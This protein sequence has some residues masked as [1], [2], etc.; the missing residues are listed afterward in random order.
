MEPPATRTDVLASIANLVI[1]PATAEFAQ[2]ARVFH[3]SAVTY[4]S[5]VNGVGDPVATRSAAQTTFLATIAAWERLEV[6]QVG[7]AGKPSTFAGG[8]GLRDLIYSWPSS[9][10]C[11]VDLKVSQEP[12][13]AADYFTNNGVDSYGLDAVEH[14]LFAPPTHSCS[15]D[16]GL[17]PAWTTL[18]PVEIERRR[19]VYA[20]AMAAEVVRHADDLAYRWSA[21]GGN[22]ALLLATPGMG[23]SPYTSELHALDEVFAAMFYVDKLT[24]DAKLGRTLGQIPGCTLI[25]CADLLELTRSTSSRTA[26]VA[27]LRGLELLVH[28]G[29]DP[30]TSRG[31]DDL[32]RQDGHGAIADALILAISDAITL[33]ESDTVPLDTLAQTNLAQLQAIFDAIKRVTDQ[34]KGPFVMALMLTIPAEGAGDAD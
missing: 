31:F 15:D 2:Q 24:K 10:P 26:I 18:G 29:S 17:D 7:P 11:R 9:N 8:E 22:F 3:A 30:F 21:T 25:P 33:L 14:L 34:L 4:A 27:N 32:L 6:M 28:G 19:A 23:S 5:A 20:E 13:P 16:V 12:A 1:A